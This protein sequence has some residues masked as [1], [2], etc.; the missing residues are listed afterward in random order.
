[1][2]Q[3][4]FRRAAAADAVLIRDLTHRAYGK[5]VPVIGR[6]PKPMSADWHLAPIQQ[7]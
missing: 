6:P 2:P 5:W 1:M 3:P 4:Q 7:E